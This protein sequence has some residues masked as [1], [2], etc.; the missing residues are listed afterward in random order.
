RNLATGLD[1]KIEQQLERIPLRADSTLRMLSLPLALR[2]PHWK[3]ARNWRMR[4]WLY[5]WLYGHYPSEIKALRIGNAVLLGTPCDCSGELVRDFDAV[6]RQKG[7]NLM[8]TSFNGGY[9]G[10]ITKDEHYDLDKYETRVMN[11]FGP[12]NAAY[13]GEVMTELIRII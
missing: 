5:G 12:Y 7:V 3:L 1:Q 2:E 13:F 4:P 9:V 10:Y 6:C 8:V 11:W